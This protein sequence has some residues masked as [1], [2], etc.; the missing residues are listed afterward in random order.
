MWGGP[1]EEEAGPHGGHAPT[2]CPAPPWVAAVGRGWGEGT[3]LGRGDTAGDTAG[4]HG[5]E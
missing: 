3:W 5:H 2:T 1:S 4:R